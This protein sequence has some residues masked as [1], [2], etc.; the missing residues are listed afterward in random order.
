MVVC[1]RRL[2]TISIHLN[3]SESAYQCLKYTGVRNRMADL[4]RLWMPVL[5]LFQAAGASAELQQGCVASLTEFREYEYGKLY[6]KT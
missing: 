1:R 6:S 5:K 2:H 3:I 4:T